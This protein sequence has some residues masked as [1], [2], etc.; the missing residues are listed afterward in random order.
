M[1][2]LGSEVAI[3]TVHRG[4][5][6]RVTYRDGDPVAPLSSEPTGAPNGTTIRLRPDPALF[7][8][9]RPPRAKLAARL[10]RLARTLPELRLTWSLGVD[11]R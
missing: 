10:R 11:P 5:A 3:A 1:I 9:V 7:S 8:D 4:R 6:M 2:A